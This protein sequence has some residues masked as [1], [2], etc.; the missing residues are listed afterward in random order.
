[1]AIV[2]GES[3]EVA[4]QRALY[5]YLAEHPEAPK[6]VA[7]YDWIFITAADPPP[8]VELPDE[9]FGQPV[10]AGDVTPWQPPMPPEPPR[11]R[12]RSH[13]NAGIPEHIHRRALQQLQRFER[14]EYDPSDAPIRYRGKPRGG[15]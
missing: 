1:M 5:A 13:N 3:E 8:T 14:D 7:A 4:Q 11:S 9:Q 10:D 15:W 2:D 6:T 12:P